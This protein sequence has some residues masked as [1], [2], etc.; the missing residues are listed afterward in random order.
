MQGNNVVRND[1]REFGHSSSVSHTEC[2]VWL[3]L[4]R[5]WEQLVLDWAC[6]IFML[7]MLEKRKLGKCKP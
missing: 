3:L 2:D 5:C 1:R 4:C 7:M 6:V